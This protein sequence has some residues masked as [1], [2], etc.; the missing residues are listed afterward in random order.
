MKKI[1]LFISLLTCSI[2]LTGCFNKENPE[3]ID[4]CII[5]GD[6]AINETEDNLSNKHLTAF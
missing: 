1:W 2:L 3:V 4:D 5:P 6:C